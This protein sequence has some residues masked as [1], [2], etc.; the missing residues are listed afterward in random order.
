MNGSRNIPVPE[1]VFYSVVIIVYNET[2]NNQVRKHERE[3]IY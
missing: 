2:I 3:K 1:F